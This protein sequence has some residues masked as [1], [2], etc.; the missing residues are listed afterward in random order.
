MGYN[1]IEMAEG[2]AGVV[3][4]ALT[5]GFFWSWWA[6]AI[7]GFLAV[8][9]IISSIFDKSESMEWQDVASMWR[10]NKKYL[11]MWLF[12]CVIGLTFLYEDITGWW[13]AWCAVWGVLI[14]IGSPLHKF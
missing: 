13:K 1:K 9:G 10:R 7:F 6:G 14:I 3:I 4:L 11:Y 5:L 12:F 2:F 8:F